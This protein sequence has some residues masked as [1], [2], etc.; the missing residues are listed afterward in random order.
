VDPKGNTHHEPYRIGKGLVVRGKHFLFLSSPSS[1]ARTYR[2]L[3][4]EIYYHPVIAVGDR[5]TP[6]QKVEKVEPKVSGVL[7]G[8]T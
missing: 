2:K 7:T 1:G 3:Q 5:F 8:A 4:D 6:A